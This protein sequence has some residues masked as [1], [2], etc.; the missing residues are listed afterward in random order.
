MKKLIYV[1]FAVGYCLIF[2][3]LFVR[4]FSPA[5][6]LP[7]YVT[8]APYGIRTNVPN[9]QYW[10]TTPEVQVQFR[11][12]SRGIRSDQEYSY[13][14]PPG[15]CRIV[16]FGDSFFM[17]YE[18]D[19]KDSFAYLLEQKL[20]VAGYSCQVINL[21]VS[22]FGTAEMLIALE[23]EGLK[24]HPD[25]VV[26]QWHVTDP[27]DNVRS[28]LFRLDKTGELV[29]A[30]AT[31]LPAIELSDWLSQFAIYR[32]LIENC[33]LY[34]AIRETIASRVKDLLATWRKKSTTT[35]KK[36]SIKTTESS[37][38]AVASPYPL[39]LSTRLLQAAQQLSQEHHAHFC[40]IEI[41]KRLS[42]TQYQSS[43]SDFSSEMREKLNMLSPLATF[44]THAHPDL[45]LYFEKGHFHL[46]PQGN[47]LLTDYF[48]SELKKTSWLSK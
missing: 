47:Q 38:T 24:Y 27:D 23:N 28:A 42:R 45:K 37:K 39:I 31:Y 25:I 7:R 3:E 11:I 32:W 40:V 35:E 43:L 13:E 22:G 48:V 15:Q 33:Q 18:V 9:V 21:A 26:F 8:G 14:K 2:G 46:T 44:E 5:P 16:L 10:Q 30:N 17:G 4:I 29:R 36:D 34:A 41:P 6:L 19:L 1:L 12:N 20:K